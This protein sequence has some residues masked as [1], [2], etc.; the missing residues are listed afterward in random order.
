[1][2]YALGHRRGLHVHPCVL[3]RIGHNALYEARKVELFAHLVYIHRTVVFHV[4]AIDG[5]DGR[6]AHRA[7]LHEIIS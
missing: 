6:V 2:R 4:G 1:M 5:F 3:E 7:R